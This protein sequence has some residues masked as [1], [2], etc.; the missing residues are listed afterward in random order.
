MAGRPL[1]RERTAL[2]IWFWE[3]DRVLL[4][5]I[6]VLIAIGLVAVAAASPVAAIDRSTSSVAVNPLHYFYRQILWV[7]AGLVVMLFVS[8]LPRQEAR[9]LAMGMAVFFSLLLM[10]VPV[11]GTEVN[12]AYRWIGSGMLR[13]QPSEFLKPVYVVTL[14]WMLS[15]RAKDKSLPV[16]PLSGAMT[17]VIGGLLM[18]QPDFGQTVIFLGVWAVLLMLSGISMK[19]IGG[20]IG[21]GVGG[22]ALMYLLYD[23]GRDRINQ[24]LGLSADAA[25]GPTQVDLA[26]ST[27]TSGGLMGVGP[28]GGQAKFHLPEAHTDYIFS[29]VGEEFGLLA[30]IAIALVYLAIVVRVLLRLLDEDEPFIVLASAGLVA[31]MAIQAIIN[32]GVNTQLFPSKGMTLP[33]ISYGGSSMIALS[34]GVGLLLAFTRRNPYMAKT[35]YGQRASYAPQW[36]GR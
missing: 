9:R 23:N 12:G 14:A 4:A 10:L 3:I 31:Q 27:I 16:I 13:F 24:F 32:M 18:K 2:S 33:F 36:S 6:V 26:R 5:L 25:G 21:A 11:I 17:A 35:P 34:I 28:G 22:L 20:L 29:V 19:A 15:L 30:C 8:M 7:G 1:P